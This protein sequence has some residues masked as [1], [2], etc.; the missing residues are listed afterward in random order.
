MG[1]SRSHGGD[2]GNK[3]PRDENATCE[4]RFAAHISSTGDRSSQSGD[5]SSQSGNREPGPG[6]ESSDGPDGRPDASDG[7]DRCAATCC[8]KLSTRTTFPE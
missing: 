8:N 1:R 5:R 7:P 4:F 2:A 6:P 3:I